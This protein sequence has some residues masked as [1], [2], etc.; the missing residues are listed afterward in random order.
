MAEVDRIF[1]GSIPA[2]YDTLMVPLIFEAYAAATAAV[3]YTHLTLPTI[4]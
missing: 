1:A 2:F 4:A 3:S